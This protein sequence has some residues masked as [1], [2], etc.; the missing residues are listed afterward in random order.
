MPV[1][2]YMD[3]TT[4]TPLSSDL[5]AVDLLSTPRPTTKIFRNPLLRGFQCWSRLPTLP[6]LSTFQSRDQCHPL[7]WHS[8][9][10]PLLHHPANYHP[11][12]LHCPCFQFTD[13]CHQRFSFCHL[14]L[15]NGCLQISS[16][17]FLAVETTRR[18]LDWVTATPK[19]G[20]YPTHSP[21]SEPAAASKGDPP[22]TACQPTCPSSKG[23]THQSSSP[24]SKSSTYP[25]IA[26]SSKVAPQY[27]SVW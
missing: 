3:P 21:T 4:T 8:W 5:Y 20:P 12:V 18:S 23:A 7:L 24:R 10:P 13:L 27:S 25:A 11:W 19:G 26:T 1:N 15:P 2:T 16:R 17:I 9:V 14:P 6:L 22:A